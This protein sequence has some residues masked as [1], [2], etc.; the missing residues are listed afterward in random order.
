[1]RSII[2]K[3]LWSSGYDFCFT[4]NST[5]SQTVSGSTPDGTIFSPQQ[6]HAFQTLDFVCNT[7]VINVFYLLNHRVAAI[8][9]FVLD[10]TSVADS[11]AIACV[12]LVTLE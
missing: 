7:C 2:F 6:G 4:V 12:A 1:M 5:V 8:S 9:V 10:D 11:P 3:V